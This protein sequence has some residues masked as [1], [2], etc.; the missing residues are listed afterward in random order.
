[1]TSGLN[2]GLLAALVCGADVGAPVTP[3]YRPP[4]P[5]T[6]TIRRVTVDARGELM[7]DT[8]AEMRV[9]MARQ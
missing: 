3:K 9:A 5:F 7:R 8:E 1:V 4:F 6:G 2:F